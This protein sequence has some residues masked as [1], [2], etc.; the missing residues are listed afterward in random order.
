MLHQGEILGT[1]L[2]LGL[3][4]QRMMHTARC[5]WCDIVKL[6]GD[7]TVSTSYATNCASHVNSLDISFLVWKIGLMTPVLIF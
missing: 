2:E 5:D 1:I 3:L 7:W 6:G 4:S